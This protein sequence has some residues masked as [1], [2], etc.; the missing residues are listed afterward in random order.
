MIIGNRRNDHRYSVGG[1][2]GDNRKTRPAS[3]IE[4]S[5]AMPYK[6]GHT[7]KKL[8]TIPIRKER[9]KEAGRSGDVSL[10]E[11]KKAKKRLV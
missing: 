1:S 4:M 5:T 3:R 7:Y 6:D 8:I 9:E 11:T 10:K 2:H